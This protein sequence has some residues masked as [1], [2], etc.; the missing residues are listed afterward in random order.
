MTAL[1]EIVLKLIAEK[2]GAS[3]WKKKGMDEW[4]IEFY[5]SWQGI[6]Y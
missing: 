5:L 6:E 4:L 3:L 1:K 2:G